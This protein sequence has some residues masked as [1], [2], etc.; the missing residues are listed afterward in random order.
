MLTR[1]PSRP[2]RIRHARP[3]IQRLSAREIKARREALLAHFKRRQRRLEIVATTRTAH[4]QVLDWV[5]VESQ[6]PGGVIAAPP[7]DRP[8]RELGHL[9]LIRF[10]RVLAPNTKL[11]SEII[12]TPVKQ[13]TDHAPVARG[14]L[15]CSV[16]SL[17]VSQ[18]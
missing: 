5:P 11:R 8:R 7:P 13:A 14:S 12:P 10:H 15:Y 2:P 18:A 9:H 6:I 16:I 17:S 1:N 3:S 4:G